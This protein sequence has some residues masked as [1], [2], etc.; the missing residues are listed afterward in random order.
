MLFHHQFFSSN[1]P[2]RIFLCLLAVLVLSCPQGMCQIAV[3]TFRET[4]L[5]NRLQEIERRI[6]QE[7]DSATLTQLQ[8][9][10]GIIVNELAQNKAR[11]EGIK[12]NAPDF[13]RTVP[14]NSTTTAARQK[15]REI[16]EKSTTAGNSGDFNYEH[17]AQ[18]IRRY[19]KQGNSL[20]AMK[21]L[22]EA[23]KPDMPTEASLLFDYA[24]LAQEVYNGLTAAGYAAA[25]SMD[26]NASFQLYTATNEADLLHTSLLTLA[27]AKGHQ[28][29]AQLLQLKSAMR[30]GN[31]IGVPQYN[32]GGDQVP[33]GT[34]GRKTCSLCHG[35]GWIAGSKSPKYGNTGTYWCQECGR[36]VLMSHSHDVC[37]SCGGKGTTPD[38]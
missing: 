20:A 18:L 24:V 11:P 33:Q 4:T 26:L 13:T 23:L 36:D 28:G 38:L 9:M 31:G 12:Q 3:N 27:T 22:S 35:K 10:R 5:K 21:H 37:P 30:G 34:V 17:D 8:A 19:L 15:S 32:T 6:E 16:P 29:A 25:F 14:D 1:L 2:K 7:T